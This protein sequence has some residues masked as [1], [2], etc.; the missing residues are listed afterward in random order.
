M[1]ETLDH[2]PS[3]CLHV[4]VTMYMVKGRQHSAY[5]SITAMESE[6]DSQMTSL[7]DSIT[8]L[9][10]GCVYACVLYTGIAQGGFIYA[11]DYVSQENA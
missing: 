3:S 4:V 5:T 2:I 6:T 8:V 7:D 1:N 11:W 10:I 9:Q